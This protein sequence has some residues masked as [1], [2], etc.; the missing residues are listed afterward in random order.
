MLSNNQEDDLVSR[1]IAV[2]APFRAVSG[3]LSGLNSVEKI[4]KA[5]KLPALARQA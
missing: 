3:E 1:G 5:S 2:L 4:R